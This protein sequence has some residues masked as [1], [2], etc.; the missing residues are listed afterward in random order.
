LIVPAKESK[1][2]SLI[3]RFYLLYYHTSCQTAWWKISLCGL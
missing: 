3:G 1:I 2:N